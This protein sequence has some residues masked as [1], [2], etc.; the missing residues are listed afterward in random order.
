MIFK[1]RILGLAGEILLGFHSEGQNRFMILENP[2]QIT[3]FEQNN[4][5]LQNLAN[6]CGMTDISTSRS[7]VRATG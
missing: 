4:I 7:M 5:G 2:S 6:L 3:R 1:K